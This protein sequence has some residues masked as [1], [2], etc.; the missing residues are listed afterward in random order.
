[1]YRSDIGLHRAYP[2]RF[3]D[4]GRAFHSPGRRRNRA[5]VLHHP[6]AVLGFDSSGGRASADLPDERLERPGGMFP[7]RN[8]PEAF[9]PTFG[10]ENGVPETHRRTLP[11][12]HKQL[13]NQS[14]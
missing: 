10:M 3:D 9:D 1:M 6:F 12:I 4:A 14:E 13:H 8:R 7:R 11:E 2:A 5:N